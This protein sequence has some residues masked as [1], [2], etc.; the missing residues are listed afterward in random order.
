MSSSSAHAPGSVVVVGAGMVGLSTAWF[1]QERGVDVTVV[2][3]IGVAAGSSWGNAGWLAPALTTPLPE[4]AVL[5]YGVK[6]V[7]SPSSPVYVPLRPD[8]RM[9]SFLLRFARNCTPKRWATAMGVFGKVGQQALDAYDVMTAGGVAEPT[10][11]AEPFMIGLG[12][13]KAERGFIEELEH[14]R[15]AGIDVDYH[16]MTGTEARAA[17]PAFG[18]GVITGVRLDGQ[19]YIDPGRFVHA[20]AESVSAR[21]GKV[22]DGVD[23]AGVRDLG[24]D[25]VVVST[26]TGE[27]RADSVVLA[28]GAWL[29]DLAREFGVRQI[30]QAG[31][32]YS[33]NVAAEHLPT[34]PVYFPDVRLACTPLDGRLRVAGTM[35]FRRP[36][37]AFDPRRVAAMV[38]AGK[39]RLAGIDW[40]DR[41]DEWV[42]SRPCTA[43]GLPLIGA[44]RSP[45]VHV[46]GGHGMWG[47][48]WGPF[49]GQMA[50]EAVVTG[51]TPALIAPFDPLR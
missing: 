2:D 16:V 33:F 46:A 27:L 1:L 40:D 14:I 44:T 51:T 8:L 25:G 26:S 29:G 6:A 34:G 11:P 3:R 20:L 49:T 17:E 30:V 42:G 50:A 19:R 39:T 47:V 10:R 35:E 4:P 41:R 5:S 21:G 7:V 9:L 37:A 45:R 23:V 18:P 31:R 43:D 32:G 12:S 28:G 38:A 24:A 36:D 15:A 22:M 48:A 13:V